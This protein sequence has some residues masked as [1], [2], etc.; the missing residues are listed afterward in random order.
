MTTE[1]AETATGSKQGWTKARAILA[2]G[3][4][5]GVGAAITLAAWTDNEW[6]TGIFGSGNFGIEGS[7]DGTT[8]ADHPTEAEAEELAFTVGAENLAPDDV[9]YAPFAVQL[10]RDSTYDAEVTIA[11]A[12]DPAL[13][14]VTADYVFTGTLGCSEAAYAAGTD[15]N[16]ATFTLDSLADVQ[17]VC[18]RVTAG[19]DLPQGV[20][21]EITWNFAAVSGD[22]L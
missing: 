6:A 2:G 20:T 14:G 3:L 12:I 16:A 9:V 1:R 4:V 21:G 18:F 19:D 11:Q 13:V 8:F 10:E 15:E 5:L 22:A 7:T 17:N